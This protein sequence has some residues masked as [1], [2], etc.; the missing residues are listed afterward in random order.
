MNAFTLV[1]FCDVDC[2]HQLGVDGFLPMG[3]EKDIYDL[4]GRFSAAKGRVGKRLHR[5]FVDFF[6]PEALP[7]AVASGALGLKDVERSVCLPE[8]HICRSV[9]AGI[10]RAAGS[11]AQQY[12]G[13]GAA[14]SVRAVA[15]VD[16]TTHC[17]GD[18]QATPA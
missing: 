14:G 1:A 4:S 7:V 18:V 10:C 6:T 15:D 8:D 2:I 9:R 17:M 3:R 13:D 5:A 11:T 16:A 12:D